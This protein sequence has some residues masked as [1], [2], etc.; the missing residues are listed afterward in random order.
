[1]S[2]FL[3]DGHKERFLIGKLLH[4]IALVSVTKEALKY[5]NSN[6]F[7]KYLKHIARLYI[8]KQSEYRFTEV[9]IDRISLEV[10]AIRI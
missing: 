1:M 3:T 8:M 6:D 5:I 10:S 2:T 9:K 7:L 4:S